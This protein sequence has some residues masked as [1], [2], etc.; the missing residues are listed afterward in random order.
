MA[1]IE[2]LRETFYNSGDNNGFSEND[3]K[4]LKDLLKRIADLEK[5]FKNFSITLNIENILREIDKLNI[6][7]NG[8]ASTAELTDLKTSNSK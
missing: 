7:V 6:S 3:N 4:L 5:S 1:L 2:H 8:K